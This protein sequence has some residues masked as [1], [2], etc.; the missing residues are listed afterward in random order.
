[1]GAMGMAMPGVRAAMPSVGM[2][3]P[4]LGMGVSSI[5][6]P[7][8]GMLGMGF[9]GVGMPGMGMLSLGVPSTSVP[10]WGMPGLAGG[11]HAASSTAALRQGYSSLKDLYKPGQR[12]KLGQLRP[13]PNLTAEELANPQALLEAADQ[14]DEPRCRALVQNKD[15]KHINEI[16]SD[17]RTAL[18]MCLLR[19]LPEDLCLSI[20]KHPE[21]N[22]IN[23]ID[24]FGN[25]ILIFAASKGMSDLCI[26]ILEHDDFMGINAQDKWGATAL[27]WAA[28]QDLAT[29]C[30]AILSH[31]EFVEANRRAWSFSF[32]DKTALDVAKN[33]RCAATADVIRKHVK[34]A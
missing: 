5:G 22:Q 11:S 20:L 26:T 34:P 9:P 10:A 17:R 29:V 3:V 4:G 13:L 28:D 7:G 33:R 30:E 18:H 19:K 14:R 31:P 27:H 2:G 6:V 12:G 21:F 1:M 32:E 24:T 25:T 23:A 15:F 16:G 8:M